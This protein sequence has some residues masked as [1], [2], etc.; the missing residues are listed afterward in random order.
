ML[1]SLLAK[2]WCWSMV[3]TVNP[4]SSTKGSMT[5]IELARMKHVLH[6][7]FYMSNI[8]DAQKIIIL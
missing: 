5:H 4:T 8:N 6:D 3:E 7:H 1:C 2:G